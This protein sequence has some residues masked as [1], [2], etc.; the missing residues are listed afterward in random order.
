MHVQDVG[1]EILDVQFVACA[2][3]A[4]AR[5]LVIQ[6]FSRICIS[7]HRIHL[8]FES[9]SQSLKIITILKISIL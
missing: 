3:L 7:L 9:L 4:R 1:M 2:I 5:L 6:R 8:C